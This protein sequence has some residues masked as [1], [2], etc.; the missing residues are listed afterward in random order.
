MNSLSA[1]DMAIDETVKILF[2]KYFFNTVCW[3]KINTNYI[4]V[5]T[6]NKW[7]FFCIS[8]AAPRFFNLSIVFLLHLHTKHV[9]SSKDTRI[10]DGKE[11]RIHIGWKQHRVLFHASNTK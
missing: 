11:S 8:F 9:V 2:F 5:Y 6:S 4:A 1:P 7:L 3:T 10:K